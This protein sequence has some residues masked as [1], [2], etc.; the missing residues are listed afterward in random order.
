M[1]KRTVLITGGAKGIG[2]AITKEFAKN[3]YN[4][5]LTYNKSIDKAHELSEELKALYDADV[6]YLKLDVRKVNEIN[7][8]Y[9]EATERFGFVDTLVNNAAISA[10]RLFCDISEDDW[11]E[12]IDTNLSGAFR[13]T[14]RFIKDMISEKNGNIIF[15]SSVW[16]QTGGSC[17]VDYSAAKAG[18]LGMSKALA[19]ELGP[20]NI[21]VNCICPGVIMTDMLSSFSNEELDELKEGTPL[22]RLGNPEEVAKSVYYLASEQASFITG[23]VIGVNGGFY[24]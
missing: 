11:D 22:C 13:V 19:K 20:S 21:R 17:E 3:G 16:A 15:I 12:M 9:D 5:V 23:Q 7:A 10:Q 18:L 8:V 24:I 4:V 1:K 6:L 2:A 14:K